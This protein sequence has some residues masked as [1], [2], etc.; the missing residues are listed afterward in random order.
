MLDEWEK[1]GYDSMMKMFEGGDSWKGD[2][3]NIDNLTQE[4]PQPEQEKVAA[5]SADDK[6][7]K[8]FN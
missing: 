8:L 1:T 3:F 2:G 4:L 7:N 6:W 5:A